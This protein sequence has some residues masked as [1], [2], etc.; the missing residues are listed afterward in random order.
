MS[1]KKLNKPV[2]YLLVA[3]SLS[4]TGCKKDPV[5]EPQP[6]PTKKLLKITEDAANHTTFTYNANGTLNKMTQVSND[7]GGAETTEF[8]Y[9][10]NNENKVTEV[11]IPGLVKFKYIYTNNKITKVELYSNNI[12]GAYDVLTYTG[13]KITKIDKYFWATPTTFEL[14]SKSECSYYDNGNIKEIKDY[15]VNN[16]G[17]FVYAST[18]Q[19]LQYDTKKNPL[20]PFAEANTGIFLDFLSE[21]NITRVKGLDSHAAVIMDTEVSYTYGA[22]GYPLTATTKI[23]ENGAVTNST[24]TY[25]Y[26]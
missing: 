10:Y 6:V 14:D 1:I 22:D 25:T 26:E 16:A 20:K 11:T 9:T 18:R 2:L 23:T 19:F 8:S 3:A 15:V 7:G 12:L 17:Q 24:S 4:I 5:N 21:N 13:D